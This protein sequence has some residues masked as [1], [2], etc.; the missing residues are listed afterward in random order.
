VSETPVSGNTA[1]E[2][3]FEALAAFTGCV[4]ESLE[5]MCSYSL[6]IGETYV[7][8]DPDDGDDCEDGE[9]ACSQAWV[10]V[11]SVVPT[12]KTDSFDGEDC[13]AVLTIGL[14]VGVLRCMDIPEDGEA[15][16]ASEVMAAAFQSMADMRAIYCAA[17]ACEV[18]EKIDSGTWSPDGPSGG[19]YGGIWTFTVEM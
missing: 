4:G 10:R 16:K 11:T 18:W 13:S 8:F 14:E 1:D 6:T 7:P 12:Y 19:Q 15:P 2:A 9:A 17:M 3:L 5:D